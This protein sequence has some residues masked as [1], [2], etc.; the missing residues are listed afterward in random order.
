MGGGAVIKTDSGICAASIVIFT[1]SIQRI[2]P[3]CMWLKYPGDPFMK[4][5]STCSIAR[6]P[7]IA[8]MWI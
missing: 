2:E 3:Q 1:K 6:V 8:G 5:I 7:D 4:I